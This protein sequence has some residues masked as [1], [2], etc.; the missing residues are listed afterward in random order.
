MAVKYEVFFFLTSET[1]RFVCELKVLIEIEIY[2]FMHK[3]RSIFVGIL[4]YIFISI[5]KVLRIG[6]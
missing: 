2:W 4:H 6:D 3:V 1:F 5:S